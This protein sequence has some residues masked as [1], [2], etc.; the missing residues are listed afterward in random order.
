M[1]KEIDFLDILNA[2]DKGFG[3]ELNEASLGRVYQHIIKKNIDSYGIIT[4]WRNDEGNP[5]LRKENL[6]N[7]STLELK[8]RA[9]GLG[10]F[11]MTGHWQECKDKEIPYEEC[12]P[13]QL[14][15]VIEPSLFVPKIRL[16]FIQ[17][18]A[19]EYDQDAFVYSGPETGGKVIIYFR[20]GNTQD[21]GNFSPHKIAQ[22]Y[23]T[24]KGKNFVFEY[25][26]Q[27]YMEA[28]TETAWKSQKKK[29]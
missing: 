10:F 26:A 7:F 28:L 13:E 18:L 8:I 17:S 20:G 11:K 9:S 12:P 2:R 3:S 15:D 21:L 22:G 29:R 24:V 5:A 25:T 14:K 23:S 4:S 27:S 16:E 19:T 6:K 1:D